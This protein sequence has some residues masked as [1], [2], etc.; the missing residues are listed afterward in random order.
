MF[1]VAAAFTYL[2]K[3]LPLISAELKK[4]PCFIKGHQIKLAGFCS[5]ASDVL[6]KSSPDTAQAVSNLIAAGA[7]ESPEQQ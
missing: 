3:V 6:P 5:W 4:S 7:G 2:S 1:D